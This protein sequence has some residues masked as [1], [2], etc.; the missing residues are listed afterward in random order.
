MV[1][2]SVTCLS[3]ACRFPDVSLARK[4]ITSLE[5]SHPRKAVIAIV[6]LGIELEEGDYEEEENNTA[7]VAAF[8][9]MSQCTS[10][11]AVYF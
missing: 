3:Y 8:S 7:A 6:V 11:D 4:R 2:R 10:M 1:T 9:T 5:I